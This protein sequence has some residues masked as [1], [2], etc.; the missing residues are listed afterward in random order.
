MPR[1]ITPTTWFE[2]A[3]STLAENSYEDLNHYAE[4]LN[5][6]FDQ[7]IENCFI[8]LK[9]ENL[10]LLKQEGKISNDQIR[11]LEKLRETVLNFPPNKWTPEAFDNDSDWKKVRKISQRLKDELKI[12]PYYEQDWYKER[13]GT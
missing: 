1:K 7:I 4:P 10:C 12:I 11:I 8:A 9:N 3:I 6:M 5:E 2:D 13:N